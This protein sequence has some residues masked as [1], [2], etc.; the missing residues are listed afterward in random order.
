M[1]WQHRESA[2]RWT[3]NHDGLVRFHFINVCYLFVAAF[4]FYGALKNRGFPS[5]NGVSDRIQTKIY[6]V[7]VCQQ[8]AF[9][10]IVKI[11]LSKAKLLL[12]RSPDKISPV[13]EWFGCC[14]NS[15]KRAFWKRNNRPLCKFFWP[16]HE[17]FIS[18]HA[19]FFQS[20][21]SY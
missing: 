16:A 8:I 19:R 1:N 21:A 12:D 13:L 20:Y 5:R 11:G 18:F 15:L 2:P 10:I 7:F 17:A 6:S 9:Q 4:L 3:D 14:R